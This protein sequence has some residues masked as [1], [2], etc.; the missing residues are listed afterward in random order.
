MSDRVGVGSVQALIDFRNHLI[1][2]DDTLEAEYRGMVADW[3]NLGGTWTDQ[4]YAEFGTALEEVGKGIERYLAV[5]DDHESH[6]LR[7]IE[8]LRAFL[9]A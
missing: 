1:R 5:T 3:R 7:L 8:R 6:L 9:E 4:K 2:F